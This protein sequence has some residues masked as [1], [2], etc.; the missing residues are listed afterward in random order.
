MSIGANQSPSNFI[1]FPKSKQEQPQQPQS[2]TTLPGPAD[3]WEKMEAEMRSI[4]KEN[5]NLKEENEFLKKELMKL[6]REN[7]AE[8]VR[9]AEKYPNMSPDA[10]NDLRG[11]IK[12]ET[13]EIRELK[14]KLDMVSKQ[15]K[16]YEEIIEKLEERIKKLL[17]D[18]HKKSMEI[19]ELR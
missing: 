9:S 4:S 15:C 14:L 11:T 6:K 16:M 7:I 17:Q 1:G 10:Y 2:D 5:V 19:D 8:N 12:K 18:Q 3:K 13:G